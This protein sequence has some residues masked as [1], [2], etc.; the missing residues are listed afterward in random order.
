MHELMKRAD[1]EKGH[2]T[3]LQGVKGKGMKGRRNARE[4]DDSDIERMY[5]RHSF[6]RDF[7]CNPGIAGSG[8][9]RLSEGV[10]CLLYTRKG[11]QRTEGIFE[12]VG[13]LE[14]AGIVEGEVRWIMLWMQWIRLQ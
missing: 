7:W 4:T 5:A 6:A 1:F 10:I 3:G 12:E 9:M 11:W 14:E 2:C 13:I 8:G